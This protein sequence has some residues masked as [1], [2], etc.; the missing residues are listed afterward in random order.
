MNF[1]FR[2]H[3]EAFPRSIAFVL[4][5][6]ENESLFWLNL[7]QALRKGI[8]ELGVMLVD[9]P[10]FSATVR[11]GY[12]RE[13]TVTKVREMLTRQGVTELPYD[14]TFDFDEYIYVNLDNRGR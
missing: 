6:E 8:D 2:P 3:Q 14:P 12:D 9:F 7:E 1:R 10:Y 13:A 4:I 11:K 5:P